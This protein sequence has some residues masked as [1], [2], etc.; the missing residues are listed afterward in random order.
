MN[1][2]GFFRHGLLVILCIASANAYSDDLPL[3]EDFRGTRTFVVEINPKIEKLKINT[4]GSDDNFI[5]RVDIYS[6][7]TGTLIQSIDT[8][9]D[10][11][12][13]CRGCAFL[14]LED[15]NLDGFQDLLILSQWGSHGD[16]YQVWLYNPSKKRFERS[17]QLPSIENYRIDKEKKELATISVDSAFEGEEK[18]YKV[19]NKQFTLYKKIDSKIVGR[20]IITTT[21]ELERGKWRRVR[22]DSEDLQ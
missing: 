17:K 12:S 7:A 19:R 5:E 8:S 1:V 20:K 9:S 18:Y 4:I 10:V 2:K 6:D 14:K 15:M 13:V 21:R 3:T 22:T 16:G 11:I